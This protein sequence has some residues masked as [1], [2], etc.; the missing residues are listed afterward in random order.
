MYPYETPFGIIMKINRQPLP[1]C[2]PTSSSGTTS[3]GANIPERLIGNWITYDTCSS[4]S[5]TSRKRFIWTEFCRLHRAAGNSSATNT[6]NRRSPNSA[7]HI[8][9]HVCMAP[10]PGR[11]PPE[12]R[13]KTDAAQQALI[14]ET[15]FAF[16][17][18]FAF[19]PYSPE[20]VYRYVNFLAMFNRLDDAILVAQTCSDF[21]PYNGQVAGLV[22]KLKEMKKQS[23]G[24]SQFET[25]LQ[26]METEVRTNP[27]NFQNIFNLASAYFQMR[28]TDRVV[29]LF[30]Q[31][32][33]NRFISRPEVGVIA[34]FFAQTGNMPKLET[35][36][37]KLST[38]VPNEPEPWYDLAATKLT[39]GKTSESL[40]DLRTS[41]DLSAKR[42]K[43]D[44]KAR[45]MLAE[46][47]K[48]HRFD[49]PAQPAGIP[50]IVPPN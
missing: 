30:D 35:T 6:D 2:P 48:D 12:Y 44:P 33:A 25:E 27:T 11:R 7:V 5:P 18:S 3:S 36:L 19:C 40:Q 21:D 20:A 38:L 49:S 47:R 13:Q 26:R 34:Q 46:L 43:Q 14:R 9:R 24:R 28:Q 15:D 32:L 4:K 42:L 39:L 1:S 37:E 45:D 23:A 8:G 16:K 22:K 17:Q 10:Q 29:A 41:L 31:A 50:K